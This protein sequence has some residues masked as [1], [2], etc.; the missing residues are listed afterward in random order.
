M[1]AFLHVKPLT[2]AP[3]FSYLTSITIGS[4][5]QATILPQESSIDSVLF[6]LFANKTPVPS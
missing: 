1:V 2:V 5:L 4:H 6:H 3:S